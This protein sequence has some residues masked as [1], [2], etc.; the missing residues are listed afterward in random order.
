MRHGRKI[1]EKKSETGRRLEGTGLYCQNSKN[2][3]N[4]YACLNFMETRPAKQ[5][6]QH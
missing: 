1:M 2:K 6:S 4:S 5:E 3:D